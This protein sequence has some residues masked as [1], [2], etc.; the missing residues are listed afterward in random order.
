MTPQG[1]PPLQIAG[2]PAQSRASG[3]A[4]ESIFSSAPAVFNFGP[5]STSA[6]GGWAIYA[7]IAAL[8]VVA[9][10]GLRK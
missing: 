5:G 3:G 10:M 9:W 4:V 7:A 8:G 2:G 6:A 1:A